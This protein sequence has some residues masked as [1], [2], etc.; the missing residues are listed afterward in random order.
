VETINV[1]LELRMSLLVLTYIDAR[2]VS[3]AAVGFRANIQNCGGADVLG[4]SNLN[5]SQID[6]SEQS[7]K[8][9]AERKKMSV[10]SMK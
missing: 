7:E 5:R 6:R 2:L 10:H 8:A 9:K 3:C 1:C 4:L